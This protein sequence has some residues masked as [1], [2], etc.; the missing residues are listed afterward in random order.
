MM[1]SNRTR[2]KSCV[3]E[4]L[5]CTTDVAACSSSRSLRGIGGTQ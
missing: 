4:E 5:S 1:S 2:T 3:V